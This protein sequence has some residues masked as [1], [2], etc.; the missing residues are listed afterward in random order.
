MLID[1]NI[2]SKLEKLSYLE[3]EAEKRAGIEH[4]IT[5]ILSFVE[6]LNEL[7]TDNLPSKFVMLDIEAHLRE[8][9]KN[10]DIQVNQ[11]II[12]NSPKSEDNFFVVSK[13]IE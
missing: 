4:E 10:V 2:L 8:D 12:K 1:E 6:N 3:I 9:I 5:E 13:I 11:K 7:N